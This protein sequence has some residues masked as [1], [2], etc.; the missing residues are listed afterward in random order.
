MGQHDAGDRLRTLAA[1][2]G[3]TFVRR[4]AGGGHEL[5]QHTGTAGIPGTGE[6]ITIPQH[7]AQGRR[8]RGGI[9][10]TARELARKAGVN[11][12]KLVAGPARRKPRAGEARERTLTEQLR[13]DEIR[14]LAA[15]AAA[16]RRSRELREIRHLMS[17]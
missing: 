12:A 14:R 4:A 10:N 11:P 15:V 1:R 3:W 5:Y 16:E 9:A 6:W 13:A 2:L 8:V 17:A 7:I